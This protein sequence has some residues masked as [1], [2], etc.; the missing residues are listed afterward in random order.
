MR[1][2]SWWWGSLKGW[3]RRRLASRARAAANRQPDDFSFFK[4]V[5]DVLYE[6]AST[7]K[8]FAAANARSFVGCAT[9]RAATVVKFYARNADTV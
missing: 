5:L 8:I 7:F 3:K 9:G 1:S 4:T 6:D 2:R